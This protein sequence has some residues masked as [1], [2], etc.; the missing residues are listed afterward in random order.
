MKTTELMYLV[1]AMERPYKSMVLMNPEALLPMYEAEAAEGKAENTLQLEDSIQKERRE[2]F[3]EIARD[4]HEKLGGAKG[5][6][7]WSEEKPIVQGKETRQ[8]RRARE[9]EAIKSGR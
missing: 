8:Q 4:M 5:D 1:G 7:N 3:E 9:R 2:Y 6:V